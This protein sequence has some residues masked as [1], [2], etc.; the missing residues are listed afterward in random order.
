MADMEI[1]RVR[2][3]V[4]A[5]GQFDSHVRAESDVSLG[6]PVPDAKATTPLTD[7]E[8]IAVSM[9]AARAFARNGN[10]PWQDLEDIAQNSLMSVLVSVKNERASHVTPGLL[11]NAARQ[12]YARSINAKLGKRHEDAR[13]AAKLKIDVSTIEQAEGRHLTAQEIDVLAKEIRDTWPN[14]RHRPIEGFQHQAQIFSSEEIT[15]LEDL[16]ADQFGH[17]EDSTAAGI[18]AEQV[19]DGVVSAAAA[20]GLLWNAMTEN[21]DVPPVKRELSAADAK[22]AREIL[23]FNGGFHSVLAGYLANGSATPEV[24]ALFAP[25]GRI[26]VAERTQIANVFAARPATA[27][28]IWVAALGFAVKPSKVRIP[29]W[30]K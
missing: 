13:A 10:T 7:S 6:G 26:S 15:G 18:L 1:V 8:A 24:R 16:P 21:W 20:R 3:G 27:E 23:N 11:A 22:R 5:G 28:K 12:Q 29:D 4:P 14:P 17:I 9:Y 25:F 30:A 19:E 2:S